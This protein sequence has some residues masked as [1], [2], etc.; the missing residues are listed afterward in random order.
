[1][2]PPEWVRVAVVEV[3]PH[4]HRVGFFAVDPKQAW[5]LRAGVEQHFGE[6]ATTLGYRAKLL[7]AEEL[8]RV[9]PRTAAATPQP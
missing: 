3:P 7:P 2:I 8:E 4:R 1:L 6:R 9:A 5:T